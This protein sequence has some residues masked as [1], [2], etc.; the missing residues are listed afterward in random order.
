[1]NMEI[2]M[3]S[4]RVSKRTLEALEKLPPEKRAR[5]E[6]IIARTQTPEA[7][8]RDSAVRAVLEKEYRQTGRIVTVGEKASPEA[9]AHFRHFVNVLRDERVAR[10][11]SIEELAARSMLDPAALSRLEAGEQANPSIVTLMRYAGAL[12]M[13]LTLALEPL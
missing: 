7:R 5:A 9:V 2:D 12:D 13:R 3:D 4:D 11:L 10:G 6:S 1:M 8:A